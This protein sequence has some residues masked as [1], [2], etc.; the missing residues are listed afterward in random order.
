MRHA[1]RLPEVDIANLLIGRLL[2]FPSS[3]ASTLRSRSTLSKEKI[4]G[5][6][7]PRDS[8]R[9]SKQSPPL[10]FQSQEKKLHYPADSGSRE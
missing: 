10:L 3:T 5:Q 9:Y 8:I 1:L 2:S 4:N 7:D 6:Q